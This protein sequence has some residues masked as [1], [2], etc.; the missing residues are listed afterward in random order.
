MIK[1]AISISSTSIINDVYNKIITLLY[2]NIIQLMII[3]Y[4]AMYSNNNLL[5]ISIIIN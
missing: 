2:Y 1:F 3:L 5:L 4:I